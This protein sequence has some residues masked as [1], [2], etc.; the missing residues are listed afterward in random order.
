MECDTCAS[1]KLKIK[2]R[3]SPHWKL[4]PITTALELDFLEAELAAH[5]R[6][7]ARGLWWS[8]WPQLLPGKAG[9]N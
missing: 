5:M 8:S 6:T 9:R 4:N 3:R 2:L 1:L 7:H